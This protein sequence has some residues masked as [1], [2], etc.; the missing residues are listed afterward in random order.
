MVHLRNMNVSHIPIVRQLGHNQWDWIKLLPTNPET[1]VFISVA[2][3]IRKKNFR[4]SVSYSKSWL[5][6]N[7]NPEVVNERKMKLT[8]ANKMAWSRPE[9]NKK[10]SHFIERCKSLKRKVS[11]FPPS[12]QFHEFLK[13][14][15][16]KRL[17]GV[18]QNYYKCSI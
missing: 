10:L 11:L 17:K 6:G 16:T 5:Q 3:K 9:E 8:Q 7:F 18:H 12:T 4:I 1:T 13:I 15:I 2:W 14:F